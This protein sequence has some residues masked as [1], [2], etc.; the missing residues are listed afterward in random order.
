[1]PSG[2]DDD[3]PDGLCDLAAAAAA[4]DEEER[5]EKRPFPPP[6]KSDD[7]DDNDNVSGLA[8]A[9]VGVVVARCEAAAVLGSAVLDG[10]A[11]TPLGWVV[12][13][14]AV[15]VALLAG[16][17]AAGGAPNLDSPPISLRPLLLAPNPNR[18][19][20]LEYMAILT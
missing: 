14:D 5:S 7:D 10:F 17:A 19:S 13:A 18:E 11:S 9:F 12:A 3:E 4:D 8:F 15:A 20:T 1:M 16:V 2:N 6:N